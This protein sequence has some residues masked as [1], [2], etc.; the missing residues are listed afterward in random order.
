[1][2]HFM[3][4]VP[5]KVKIVFLIIVVLLAMGHVW[6]VGDRIAMEMDI[7]KQFAPALLEQVPCIVVTP[8][9]VMDS[10][11]YKSAAVPI[12][13]QIHYKYEWK[14]NT[15]LGNRYSRHAKYVWAGGDVTMQSLHDKY[16]A[17]SEHPCYVNTLHPEASVLT[18]SPRKW[19]PF[20]YDPSEWM[21]LVL[22]PLLL[23][24]VFYVAWDLARTRESASQ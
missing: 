23:Y 22:F 5:R 3:E 4:Q 11:N 20:F 19:I 18:L 12:G 13:F 8:E 7:H 10:G 17:G 6:R 24:V 2:Q 15:Y 1:M 9:T 14:G 16:R 21:G